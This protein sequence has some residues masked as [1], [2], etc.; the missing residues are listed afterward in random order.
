MA[1]QHAAINAATTRRWL[2]L[3]HILFL[4]STL[5]RTSRWIL[6]NI[7]RPYSQC[8]IE[9][10]AAGEQAAGYVDASKVVSLCSSELGKCRVTATGRKKG[11]AFHD[12]PGTDSGAGHFHDL[13]LDIEMRGGKEPQVTF[14]VTSVSHVYITKRMRWC[15]PDANGCA[16]MLAPNSGRADGPGAGPGSGPMASEAP[17]NLMDLPREP[18]SSRSRHER[19]PCNAAFA[20]ILRLPAPD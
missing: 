5:R 17:V 16:G 12:L 1:V 6:L 15:L 14:R 2:D 3:N 8:S 20:D 7:Y 10:F 13:V 18:P 11:K 4:R 19:R 9:T